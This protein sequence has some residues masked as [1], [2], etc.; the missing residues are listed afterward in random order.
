ML[1]QRDYTR[2]V[3]LEATASTTGRTGFDGTLLWFIVGKPVRSAARSIVKR[4]ESKIAAAHGRP[5]RAEID[6][7]KV[8]AT[9]NRYRA[10]GIRD[11]EG[12]RI[13]GWVVRLFDAD[14]KV[15]AEQASAPPL[16]DWFRGSAE[17]GRTPLPPLPP[18]VL[19]PPAPPIS[20]K[21]GV[22]MEVWGIGGRVR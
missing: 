19:G 8:T 12:S 22:R 3:R 2:G 5:G 4:G 13:E 14:G 16:L 15:L 6:S 20:L 11:T 18:E 21:P 9:D 1:R 17:A 10:L 7:G